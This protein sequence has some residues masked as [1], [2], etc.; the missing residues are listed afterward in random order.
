MT[1][2]PA[3]ADRGD[4]LTSIE[5][6][7]EVVPLWAGGFHPTLWPGCPSED[8]G[9]CARRMIGAPRRPQ[10]VPDARMAVELMSRLSER[11]C[12]C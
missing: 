7:K 12:Q 10:V 4:P 5:A 1:L 8:A 11:G 6:P 3:R 9:C 2:T